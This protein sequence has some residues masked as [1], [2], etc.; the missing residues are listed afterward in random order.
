M[1]TLK[2]N[3]KREMHGLTCLQSTGRGCI[4][5]KWSKCCSP[6]TLAFILRA[7]CTNLYASN[8]S[9]ALEHK[10]VWHLPSLG[11]TIRCNIP[12]PDRWLFNKFKLI[13]RNV[14]RMAYPLKSKSNR[15]DCSTVFACCF[16]MVL[17]VF[18]W[19]LYA[20]NALKVNE[21]HWLV[22]VLHFIVIHVQVVIFEWI[23]HQARGLHHGGEHICRNEPPRQA[24]EELWEA[25]AACL[26][27]CHV[28]AAQA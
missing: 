23:V 4:S 6:V 27:V 1:V 3:V 5:C 9:C 25:A 10:S 13:E 18:F 21:T 14:I 7:W 19:W 16:F 11:K 24:G 26:K 28:C 17:G 8:Q 12:E 20:C 15:I 22:V 2:E